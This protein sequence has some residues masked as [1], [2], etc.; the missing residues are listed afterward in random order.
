MSIYLVVTENL[1]LRKSSL[2]V[3]IWTT[4]KHF[5]SR[6]NAPKSISDAY[7]FS[8]SLFFGFRSKRMPP[9]D[10]TVILVSNKRYGDHQQPKDVGD[11][12]VTNQFISNLIALKSTTLIEFGHAA[13]E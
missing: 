7:N 11:I 1:Q 4:L 8:L 13:M 10:V 2:S 3:P 12:L 6:L 9:T 5:T